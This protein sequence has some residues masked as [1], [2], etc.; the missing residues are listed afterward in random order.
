MGTYLGVN[1]VK[2]IGRKVLAVLMN[3]QPT[4]PDDSFLVAIMCNG[5]WAIAPEVT[6][7]NEYDMFVR[8]YNRGNYLNMELYLVPENQRD[9]CPDEGHQ[10]CID[11]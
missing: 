5:V 2:E 9:N 4:I 10:S 6:D 7:I 11:D 1:K 8:E 3:K